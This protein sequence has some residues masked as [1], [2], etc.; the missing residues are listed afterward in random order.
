MMQPVSRNVKGERNVSDMPTAEEFQETLRNIKAV[1]GIDAL[2]EATP[3]TSTRTLYRHAEDDPP[4][5][6]SGEAYED[7][8]DVF[9][10]LGL[11][12]DYT[13]RDVMAAVRELKRRAA[14]SGDEGG[15]PPGA[16]TEPPNPEA[17]GFDRVEEKPS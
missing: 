17:G 14:T 11:L 13:P 15:E 7:L 4:R 16:A 3:R 12:G 2:G 8:Y 10:E 1:K 9:E 6:M 5:S